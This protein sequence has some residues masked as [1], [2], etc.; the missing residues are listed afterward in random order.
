MERTVKEIGPVKIPSVAMEDHGKVR[1][2]AFT[3][4]FP[5]IRA[6]P[7]RVGDNGKIRMG[8][9]TPVFPVTPAK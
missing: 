5:P 1:M 8:A 4:P 9:F 6:E 3:P 7:G 2:G